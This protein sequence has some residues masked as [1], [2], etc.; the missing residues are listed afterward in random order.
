VL[1][2]HQTALRFANS[3]S[4]EIVGLWRRGEHLPNS[5]RL[6]V[7]GKPGN[8]CDVRQ[9]GQL[10]A[11]LDRFFPIIEAGPSELVLAES[12]SLLAKSHEYLCA[13]RYPEALQSA[14]SLTKLLPKAVDG[15]V[16]MIRVALRAGWNDVVLDAAE[17]ALR[18]AP[19]HP[20]LLVVAGSAAGDCGDIKQA[21]SY[22]GLFL[23]TA[24]GVSNYL[25]ILAKHSIASALDDAQQCFPAIAFCESAKTSSSDPDICQTLG[26]L[27][28]RIG[29]P[30]RALEVVDEG[31]K[32]APQHPGL[33]LHSVGA[34][35]ESGRIGQARAALRM[36]ESVTSDLDHI[37]ELQSLLETL[38][39]PLIEQCQIP[40]NCSWVV[41]NHCPARIPLSTAESI[42]CAR[43]GSVVDKYERECPHCTSTGRLTSFVCTQSLAGGQTVDVQWRCPYCRNGSLEVMR[44]S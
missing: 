35:F 24:R 22:L 37:A 13:S 15:P 11:A 1:D 17:R 4:L 43:C 36:L 34:N 19:Q 39:R 26:Y 12:R 27:Y 42:I 33:L 21:I 8:T 32:S 5:F 10:Q 41:C 31:L 20:E 6:P 25:M 16:Q 2:E 14:I 28:R 30:Q 40:R 3:G 23:E 44:D 9:P 18:L 38:P 7:L 29:D